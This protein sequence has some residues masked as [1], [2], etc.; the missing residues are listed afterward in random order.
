MTNP[1]YTGQ[2]YAG[3]LRYRPARIRRSA[4]HPIGHPHDSGVSVPPE[5]WIECAR[6]PAII[7]HEQF[8]MVRAKLI[9]NQSLA[10]RNNK[11]H[12][13]LLRALVSCGVCQLSCLARL[14]QPHNKYYVCSGK[15]KIFQRHREERCPSR[16]A[17]ADQLDE[18][19]WQ[20]LCELMSN[21]QIIAQGLARA[22]AGEWLPQELQARRENLRKGQVSLDHQLNRLTEAYLSEVI[23]LTEYK[24][25][26]HELEERKQALA[27]QEQHLKV[28]VDR[29][30]EVAGMVTSIEEF[31]QRVC[32]GL[33]TATFEQKRQLVEL[34][35][36]RVVVADGEV[37]IRY[38]IPT[39][40]S[41]EHIR[42]CHLRSDYFGGPDLID[43]LN[44]HL[45]EQ[46]RINLLGSY[47]LSRPRLR[48]LG[49]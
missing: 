20:D 47:G 2:V 48:I 33:A 27:G 11:A 44:R 18:L 12:Q 14:V 25:R 13:Y 8:E 40:P 42:F 46:V 32:A 15:A 5:E 49:L 34:L 21:P 19:V 29:Q 16:F 38:A 23:P 43:S 4:L 22:R 41:S 17:P 10:R 39:S 7:T 3:R 26:R 30:A 28:Q 31:S 35:V 1:A 37:E 36:D 45:L 6:I 9:Q 24:R